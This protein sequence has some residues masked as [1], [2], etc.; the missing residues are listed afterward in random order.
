MLVRRPKP[1]DRREREAL[2]GT[3]RPPVP[4]RRP[5]A[6][7]VVALQRSAGNAAVARMLSGPALQR[8]PSTWKTAT[9]EIVKLKTGWTLTSL[10]PPVVDRVKEYG[11]L[12][13]EDVKARTA[14]LTALEI[15]IQAWQEHQ[16]TNR[17]LSDLDKE[18]HAAV[19]VLA[20]L[21]ADERP[22]LQPR[23]AAAPVPAHAPTTAFQPVRPRPTVRIAAPPL[24]TPSFPQTVKATEG[25]PSSLEDIFELEIDPVPEETDEPKDE[26]RSEEFVYEEDPLPKRHKDDP[27]FPATVHLRVHMTKED[28][29][30]SIHATGL[31]AGRQQGIGLANEREPEKKEPDP[32]YLY[33]LDVDTP[34]PSTITAVGQESGGEVVG[35]VSGTTGDRDVNYPRGG[36]VRYP[37]QA[38]PVRGFGTQAQEA[39]AY[40]FPVPLTPRSMRGLTAFVNRHAPQAMSEQ[41][42]AKVVE[43]TLRRQLPLYVY[44]KFGRQRR[45]SEAETKTE[46]KS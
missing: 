22:H 27:R 2:E 9:T 1:T 11:Q 29:L 30:E 12:R 18:K 46:S 39:D 36:A 20:K 42:V 6:A 5:D 19:K 16:K 13:D 44:G 37:P 25:K 35:M 8:S 33:A 23:P 14:T 32:G 10:W 34:E 38:P 15:A 40:S 41:E 3:A 7:A 24:P 4:G 21:I 45:K 43:V 26:A 17:W 28:Y 31:I